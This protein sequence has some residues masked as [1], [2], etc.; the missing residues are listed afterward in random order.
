MVGVSDRS[1]WYAN[2]IYT[3]KDGKNVL[4]SWV[5]EDNNF[6]AGQPQ[7][8]GGMLSVPCK[9]GI[10]SVCDIDVVN[11]QGRLDRVVRRRLGQAVQD[12]QDAEREAAE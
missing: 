6:T 2:S 9:V 10:S 4:I 5:I 1:D 11:S 12:Q 8:W 7:G 3:H